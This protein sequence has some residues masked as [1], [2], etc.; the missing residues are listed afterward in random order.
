MSL[1][2][3]ATPPYART[4]DDVDRPAAGEELV[5]DGAVTPPRDAASVVVLRGGADGLEVLL[6]QRTHAA[7]FMPGVWVFPGGAVDRAET[8]LRAAAVRELEEEAGLV[9][10]PADLVPFSR[11]ITPAA[12]RIRFDTHFFLV[13]EPAGQT[14]RVDGSE[15]IALGWHTPRAALSG[16]LEL[17]FPTI[18]HLQ[19]FDA[20]PSADAL[21]EHARGHE[22]RPVVPKVVMEGEVARILL[23]GEPGYDD[24]A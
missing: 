21:L 12:V 11:W 4:V 9:V 14:A 1:H 22:V 17:V 23:P 10:D 8:E 2:A 20:F 19:Q 6:V 3:P 13:R 18:K 7:R 24:A 5:G 15:C 16:D